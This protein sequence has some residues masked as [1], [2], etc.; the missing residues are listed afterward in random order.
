MNKLSGEKTV[1]F[2]TK[3]FNPINEKVKNVDDDK[4][5]RSR[6]GFDPPAHRWA[7]F[8]P[9]IMIH[10]NRPVSGIHTPREIV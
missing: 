5:K 9:Q 4:K 6:L 1:N 8:H 10:L 7:C 2:A 3:Q